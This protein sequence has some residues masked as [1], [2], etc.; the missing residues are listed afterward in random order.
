MKIYTSLFF[1]LITSLAHAQVQTLFEREANYHHFNGIVLIGQADST[2]YN[3]SFGLQDDSTPITDSTR[4]DIGSITKQFTAAGILHLV[5]NGR[6]N[7]DDPINN[8][9]GKYSS[10]KWK[11]VTVHHL[12]THTSGIPSLY[13]TEQ[14]I[15]IFFPEETSIDLDDLILR[16]KDTKLLFSPGKEFSYNNSGYI[17]LAAIIE[18]VSGTSFQQFMQTSVFDYYG[19]KNTSFDQNYNAALPYYGYLPTQLKQAPVYDSSWFIGAGG[20]YSTAL[21]LAKWVKIINS[22][23]FLNE[24][25][26]AAFL[27]NHTSS[28]Y[29]YGWQVKNT[30]IIEHDGGNAGFI[31]FLSFNPATKQYHVLL[32]NRSFEQISELGKS[33]EKIR[34]LSNQIWK[35]QAGE[36]L[37]IHPEITTNLISPSTY[38][39]N[40]SK[41]LTIKSTDSGIQ[42]ELKN[43]NPARIIPNTPLTGNNDLETKLVNLT[44]H[45]EKSQ[46]WKFAS[47][48][49]GEMKFVSYS[50]L[51]R[52]GFGQMKKSV[53]GMLELIPYKVDSQHGLIR[54]KG[55]E[56]IL[57]L[58]VYFDK[59]GK[60]NGIFEHGAYSLDSKTTLEAYPIGRDSFYLDGFP[61]VE[62]PSTFT[63]V[64]D[65]LLIEQLN[66]V[67]ELKKAN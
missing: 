28:N 32:T 27:K 61:Y 5:H 8:H 66:R 65:K 10:T 46:F 49:N 55:K 54:M 53:G 38:T 6:I 16:F 52:Y 20:V 21:D 22:S 58:I 60:I 42:V 40:A 31:S 1:L 50:G 9:L 4:F 47:Y 39:L 29:G 56:S 33:S 63:I 57:D 43:G 14:G 67:V 23:D 30:G 36:K 41:K 62:I 24:E 59:N 26:Q 19:L 7:L 18:E 35:W 51:M 17:L 64:S 48:C 11:K 13:Q 12:L 34:F 2:K 3:A 45:L 37:D 25:L 44:R 15:D